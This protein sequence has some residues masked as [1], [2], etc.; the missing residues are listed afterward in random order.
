[1]SFWTASFLL[2]LP[3]E[4]LNIASVNFGR[5]SVRVVVGLSGGVDSAVAAHLLLQNGYEVVGI[6]MRNWHDESVTIN[7][8]CPWIDDS[9]DAEKERFTVISEELEGEL[10][11]CQETPGPSCQTLT[12][13]LEV[14]TRPR[15]AT[16]SDRR[17]NLKW[18]VINELRA[19][20]PRKYFAASGHRPIFDSSGSSTRAASCRQSLDRS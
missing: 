10:L 8:E 17:V 6:F 2:E 20:L 19:Y 15:I 4:I 18:I 16:K 12:A 13:S 5:M 9:N 11:R 7:N 3:L 14:A 1:M